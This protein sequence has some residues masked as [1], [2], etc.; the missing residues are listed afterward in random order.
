[1]IPVPRLDLVLQKLVDCVVDGS[2]IAQHQMFKFLVILLSGPNQRSHSFRVVGPAITCNKCVG[3]CLVIYAIRRV[4]HGANRK[5]GVRRL[6]LTMLNFSPPLS[7]PVVQRGFDAK[8]IPQL[9]ERVTLQN[10][11]LAVRQVDGTYGPHGR[12]EGGNNYSLVSPPAT[13]TIRDSSSSGCSRPMEVTWAFMT[14]TS[15]P[16]FFWRRRRS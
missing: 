6:P 1:M 3:R 12:R 15:S 8:T 4:N 9:A 2:E 16:S 7:S 13:T 5:I 11:N 14:K 10:I